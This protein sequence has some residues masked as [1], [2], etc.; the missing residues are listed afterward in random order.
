MAHLIFPGDGRIISTVTVPSRMRYV[1][2][3]TSYETGLRNQRTGKKTST[4]DLA[5]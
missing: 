2:V 5:T 3:F 1:D 4:C